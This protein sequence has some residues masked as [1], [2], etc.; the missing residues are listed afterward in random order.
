MSFSAQGVFSTPYILHNIWD[1]RGTNQSKCSHIHKISLALA[2]IVLILSFKISW[3]LPGL[4][5]YLIWN[6][7][8][9][10]WNCFCYWMPVISAKVVMMECLSELSTWLNAILKPRKL[11][12]NLLF[13]HRNMMSPFLKLP[14]ETG[15]KSVIVLQLSAKRCKIVRRQDCYF[16]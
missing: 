1:L 3:N 2:E 5:I 11:A 10:S 15:K 13:S 16:H 6:Q 8:E 9:K 4:L 14:R 7:I 12:F